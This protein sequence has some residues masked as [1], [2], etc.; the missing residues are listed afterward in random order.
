M[1]TRNST[2][3]AA[4]L[5]CVSS[6]GAVAGPS[7]SFLETAFEPGSWSA[8]TP[9]WALPASHGETATVVSD[10]FIA[11]E[12]A[13]RLMVQQYTV[14]FPEGAVNAIQPPIIMNAWTHDPAKDGAIST[15]GASVYTF[16]M[17]ASGGTAG[18]MTPRLYIFQ[19]DRIYMSRNAEHGWTTFSPSDPLLIRH[20]SDYTSADFFEVIPNSNIALNSHPDFAGEPMQFGFGIDLSAGDLEGLGTVTRE[21]GWDNL[22]MRLNL[23]PA[24][25]AASLLLGAGLMGMRRRR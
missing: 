3:A 24:P 9:F 20:F 22:A 18:N 6:A 14:N 12:P 19:G 17:T 25:G 2:L 15:I 10:R 7:V 11:G 5:F 4:L 13:N 23:V 16:P 21:I 8:M 1:I